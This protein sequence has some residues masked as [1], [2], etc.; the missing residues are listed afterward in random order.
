[1]YLQSTM[2]YRRPG[3]PGWMLSASLTAASGVGSSLAHLSAA[4]GSLHVEA[5]GVV[6]SE[7]VA[8]DSPTGSG[9]QLAPS[10]VALVRSTTWSSFHPPSRTRLALRTLA[11]PTDAS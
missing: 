4:C 2:R 7:T 1:M 5:N 6:V 10:T 8:V 11:V 9:V 3:S